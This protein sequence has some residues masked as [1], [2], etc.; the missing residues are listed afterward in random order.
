V[1]QTTLDVTRQLAAEGLIDPVAQQRLAHIAEAIDAAPKSRKW[2][3]RAR[4]GERVRWYEEP[5][6]LEHDGSQ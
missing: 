2:K 4:V 3:L 5:E 1:A 6:A